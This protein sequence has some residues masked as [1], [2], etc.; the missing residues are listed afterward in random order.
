MEEEKST[1]EGKIHKR[2]LKA[3]KK[4]FGDIKQ[5]SEI[6]YAHLS[7][8]F[9]KSKDHPSREEV[10]KAL[11]DLREIPK[12]APLIAIILSSPIP[13]SSVGYLVLVSVLK[14]MSKDK[15]NLVP[16]NFEGIINRPS[17]KDESGES[18]K[19]S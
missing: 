6:L 4:E 11:K 17:S 5:A 19:I 15:I 16:K 12:I 14:K 2:I 1:Q 9:D 10:K 13:G 8:R 7:K 18:D 3:W